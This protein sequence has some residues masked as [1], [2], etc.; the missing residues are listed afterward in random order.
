MLTFNPIF[1]D[2]AILQAGKA[3]RICGNGE[4]EI[5][6]I[7]GSLSC[8]TI[9]KNGCWSVEF[10]SQNYGTI[11]D[12]TARS[13]D[14]T[15][16]A[17]NVIFG[18]VYLLAGQSNMQFKLH[19]A[20]QDGDIYECHD[21]RLFSTDRLENNDYFKACDGWV[22]CTKETAPNFSAIGYF[23]ARELH[24]RDGR[25]I[26]LVSCYQG[27]SV[28]QSWM[29]QEALDELA[30]NMPDGELHWDHHNP[31][32]SKWN[33]ISTLYNY[34]FS[35]TLPLSYKAVVWYQGESNTSESESCF[36][37][38]MLEKMITL[39]RADLRDEMLP[40]VI[41]QIAD[42]DSRNDEPWKK[43]QHAQE[44]VADRIPL[45]YFVKCADVCESNNIHPPTK[46]VLAKRIS[47]II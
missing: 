44:E 30:L 38:K 25:P 20:V 18:D 16:T 46:H 28:I 8:S 27:A 47:E 7:L 14:G 37:D 39:W 4:G 6:V 35:Q 22:S 21:I 42:Y 31:L 10:D 24:K 33:G 19:E 15:V 5:E 45:C 2:N 34:A 1:A 11:C 41:I 29:S 40:F 3:V 36:Y 12:L 13:A 17:K 26:G 43:V 32:Y 23:L 9:A